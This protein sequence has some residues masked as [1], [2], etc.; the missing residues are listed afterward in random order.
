MVGWTRRR[1]LHANNKR[2]AENTTKEVAE[3]YRISR[4]R[5]RIMDVRSWPRVLAYAAGL[6]LGHADEMAVGVC[7]W[8]NHI[9]QTRLLQRGLVRVVCSPAGLQDMY[10]WRFGI[11]CRLDNSH[12]IMVETYYIHTESQHALML[13]TTMYQITTNAPTMQSECNFPLLREKDQI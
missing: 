6:G 11:V 2:A 10:F 9:A 1:T 3:K 8:T 5:R 4:S 13:S 7:S 12:T